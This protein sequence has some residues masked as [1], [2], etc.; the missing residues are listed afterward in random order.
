MQ[1]QAEIPRHFSNLVRVEM[2]LDGLSVYNIVTLIC[3]CDRKISEFL[4]MSIRHRQS[5]GLL[6]Q[7]G[8]TKPLWVCLNRYVKKGLREGEGGKGVTLLFVHAN[9]FPKEVNTLQ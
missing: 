9:G 6:N 4:L 8:S 2:N 1:V 7:P 5:G 3:V